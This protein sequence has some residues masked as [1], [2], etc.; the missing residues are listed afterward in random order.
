MLIHGL[1]KN[2]L[3]VQRAKREAISNTGQLNK[4][5]PVLVSYNIL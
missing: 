5:Q 3:S 2:H 4:V 1:V